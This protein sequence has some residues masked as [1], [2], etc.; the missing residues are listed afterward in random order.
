MPALEEH[1]AILD[2]I[3][4]GDAEGADAATAAHAQQSLRWWGILDATFD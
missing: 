2:A 3:R 4:R 1:L